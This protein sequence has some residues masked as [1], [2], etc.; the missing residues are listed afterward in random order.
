MSILQETISDKLYSQ[1]TSAAVDAA[2]SD[3]AAFGKRTAN[4]L[5]IAPPTNVDEIVDYMPLDVDYTRN[6]CLYGVSVTGSSMSEIY[7][8]DDLMATSTKIADRTE[9]PFTTFQAAGGFVNIYFMSAFALE[10]GSYLLSVY[11]GKEYTDYPVGRLFRTTDQGTTWTAV[12]DMPHGYLADFSLTSRG[13]RLVIG[14]YGA[15]PDPVGE[16]GRNIYLSEDYGATWELIYAPDAEAGAHIHCAIIDPTNPNRVYVSKGDSPASELFWLDYNSETDTWDRTSSFPRIQ[17]THMIA[18]LNDIYLTSDNSAPLIEKL[19]TTTGELSIAWNLPLPTASGDTLWYNGVMSDG[20]IFIIKHIAGMFY[21]GVFESVAEAGGLYVSRDMINWSRLRAYN[22]SGSGGYRRIAGVLFGKLIVGTSKIADA[23]GQTGV[24][25]DVPTTRTVEAVFTAP[26]KTNL[27]AASGDADF[28]GAS[29]NWLKYNYITAADISTDTALHGSKCLKVACN[30]STG[31]SGSLRTPYLGF[32]RTMNYT[33]QAGDFLTFSVWIKNGTLTGSQAF[34]I[35]TVAPASRPLNTAFRRVNSA[36]SAPLL[37]LSGWVRYTQTIEF[38]QNYDASSSDWL[39]IDLQLT[40]ADATTRYFYLDCA[41]IVIS[42]ADTY[43]LEPFT[44]GTDTKDFCLFPG[45]GSAPEWTVTGMWWPSFG[46]RTKIS[47]TYTIAT[48]SDLAGNEV[49]LYWDKT[50]SKVTLT[51]T[52]A[53][54]AA[55]ATEYYPSFSDCVPFAIAG[56]ATGI[57]AVVFDPYNGVQ[58]IGDMSAGPLTNSPA[59]VTVG[60]SADTSG[61]GY[62]SLIRTYDT[63]MSDSDIQTAWANQTMETNIVPQVVRIGW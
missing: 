37:S 19:D 14:E 55:A 6:T 4:K 58:T 20:Y 62:F 56:D 54:S 1:R 43:L 23:V 5:A 2:F 39:Q 52:G 10:D 46:R 12:L 60:G 8:S 9:A 40:G 63:A 59:F 11:G 24:V 41:S 48:V 32:G 45:A 13:Q 21:C 16:N 49:V 47:G 27:L 7:I 26:A 29:H 36:T 15:K 50:T 51:G 18:Y 3:V 35:V 57:K 30:N 44:V 53:F 22:P 33:P 31:S 17:P 25:M 61:L 28:E 34:S 38:L 42:T